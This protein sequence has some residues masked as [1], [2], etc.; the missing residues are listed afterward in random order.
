MKRHPANFMVTVGYPLDS[1][2]GL[3]LQGPRTP[4]EVRRRGY[5]FTPSPVHA[6]AFKSRKQAEHKA[7]IV[8]RH[9]GW[10]EGVLIVE[11]L[12][13]RHVFMFQSRFAPKILDGTKCTTIR[14]PRKRQVSAGDILDLR[15]WTGAPY[16]SK[17]RKLVEVVCA[18]EFPALVTEDWIVSLRTGTKFPLEVVARSEGFKDSAEML[19]WF[20]QTHGLPFTGTLYRWRVK[21]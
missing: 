5:G 1:L 3:H 15:E 9:M 20:K 10:G 21:A 18:Q 19:A 7:R 2:A 8:E 4:Q 13:R 16:R 12:P 11:E 17:Q 6:W 14:L